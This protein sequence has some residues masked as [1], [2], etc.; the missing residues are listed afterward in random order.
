VVVARILG[1]DSDADEL[2]HDVR[3]LL[4]LNVGG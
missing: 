3:R 1:K 2:R 4:Q